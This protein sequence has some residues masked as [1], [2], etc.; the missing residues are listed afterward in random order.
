MVLALR[1][2]LRDTWYASQK[3]MQAI[4]KLDKIYYSPVV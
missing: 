3:A 2:V 4:D 1:T